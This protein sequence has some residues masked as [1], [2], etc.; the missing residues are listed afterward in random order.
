MSHYEFPLGSCLDAH[1]FEKVNRIGEGTYGTVYCARY[2]KNNNLVALKRI[3]LHN[4][5]VDG[6]PITTIREIQCLRSCRDHPNIVS[7]LGIAAG[8][9][10]ESIFLVFEYC[11]HDLGGIL[12]NIQNPFSESEVKCI[13]RQLINALKF[14]HRNYII[15]RDIK[16]SNILYNNK[17]EVKLADFGMARR[18]SLP[19]KAKMTPNIVTLYYRSPELLFGDEKYSSLSDIWSLGCVFAEILLKKP[20]FAGSDEKEQLLQIFQIL[21]SPNAKIWPD[22]IFLPVIQA[23]YINLEVETERFPFNRLSSV[24][25]SLC[26]EGHDLLNAMFTFDPKRRI[27]AKKAYK[28]RYFEVSPFPRDLEF[29]PTFPTFHEKVKEKLQ[30]IESMKSKE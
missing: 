4:E 27:T 11:E 15:H 16:P 8:S 19:S 12:K 10:K 14:L 17:G 20:M 6:F 26:S 30:E 3:I 29:M 25:P 1:E 7:M 21:G 23:N 18:F 22:V 5:D 9:R 13:L 28:H 24:F 2:L